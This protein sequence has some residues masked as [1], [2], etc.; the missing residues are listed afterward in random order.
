MLDQEPGSVLHLSLRARQVWHESGSNAAAAAE[1][2]V[3]EA[4]AVVASKGGA[5]SDDE[6][7]AGIVQRPRP[8][9][10]VARTETANNKKMDPE[11]RN[12]CIIS[13]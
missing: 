7:T 13:L 4:S 5:S 2:E 8:R 9:M 6:G 3:V 1:P 11:H 10:K 12:K